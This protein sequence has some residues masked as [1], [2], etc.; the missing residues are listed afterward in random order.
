MHAYLFFC[1][2]VSVGEVLAEIKLLIV[3]L[4]MRLQFIY[5]T[6]IVLVYKRRSFTDSYKKLYAAKFEI[7]IQSFNQKCNYLKMN[8]I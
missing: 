6:H 7:E 2:G 3:L 8:I 1:N 4:L 5:K